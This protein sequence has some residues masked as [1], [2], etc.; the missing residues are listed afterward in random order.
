MSGYLLDTDTVIFAMRSAGASVRERAR[1]ERGRLHVSAVTAME[2]EYGV[3]RSEDVMR[4]RASTQQVLATMTVLDFDRS[5]AEHAGQIRAHLAAA[6]TPIG[7]YDVMIAGHARSR[8]LIL[9]THNVREF[10]RVPELPV[11]DWMP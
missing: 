4:N 7:A 1:A 5:A 2:L 9:V 8:G 10:E 11:E 3:E 6:G